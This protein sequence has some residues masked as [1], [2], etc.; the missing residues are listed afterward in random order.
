M[1]AVKEKTALKNEALRAEFPILSRKVNGQPLVYLDNAASSQKPQAVI[2]AISAY[3]RNEHSNVHRGVHFLSQLATEKFEAARRTMQAF[4]NAAHER[5]VIFTK[6]TTEGINLV[7]SGMA[8]NFLKPGDEVLISEMEHHSNIV[9]WQMA[10]EQSGARLVVVRV[11]DAGELDMADFYEKLSHRT[12]MVSI[13]HISNALGTINPVKEIV[14]A[15][16]DKGAWVLIDGAQ[17]APHGNV[18]VQDMDCDFYT[19][20]AH[21]MYGPT[22][23]GV[24][25]GKS[26]MLEALPPYQGGGEM[27]KTVSFEKTTYNELPFKF[28]AGTP[29]MAGAIGMAAAADWM[30]AQGHDKL[31]AIEKALLHYATERLGEVEGIQ[32]WGSAKEK[33]SVVSFLVEGTHPYDVG[34]IID[35]MGVAV[36]TGHH[37]TQ[38]LMDKYGIPGTIRA[39]FAAYNTFEEI[40]TLVAAV[41]RAANMLR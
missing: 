9:P 26:E 1:N 22:G 5:E 17:G 28:E 32:F 12:K 3:Y 38:P 33:T 37:C 6:G 24:L 4:V 8:R 18:D 14:R 20:S 41:Q 40:D 15:A 34:A 19:F 10:C 35:K 30:A 2:D 36:R 21:K 7:A 29:N 16:H 39:S 23:M 25:Y 13:V 31:Q 27:I 11:S